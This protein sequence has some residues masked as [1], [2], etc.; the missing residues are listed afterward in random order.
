MSAALPERVDVAR[1]V[2]GRRVYSGTLPFSSMSR[3]RDALATPQGEARYHVEFDKDALGIA[4]LQLRVEAGLPLLCQRT[5]EVFALPVVI[6]ERLGLIAREEDEAGLPGGYEPLLV[7]DGSIDLAA[8]IEDELI[9]AV[10]V[11][12]TRPGVP[13]DWVDPSAAADEAPAPA[14]PF[15][16]LA[17]LKDKAGAK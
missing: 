10:P 11:V 4:Y 17:G 2:Q 12:P 15:A 7:A 3:L 1:Q 14:N 8:V 6:D 5:L 13:L 9:L 16:A